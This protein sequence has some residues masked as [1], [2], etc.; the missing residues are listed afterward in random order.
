MRVRTQVALV[1]TIMLF[2]LVIMASCSK[3]IRCGEG[4]VL[5]DGVCVVVVASAKPEQAQVVLSPPVPVMEPPRLQEP[6]VNPPP[7]AS[8]SQIREFPQNVIE[9]TKNWA[10]GSSGNQFRKTDLRTSKPRIVLAGNGEWWAVCDVWVPSRQD[11]DGATV[12]LRKADSGMWVVIEAGP[13][14]LFEDVPG[15]PQD[16]IQKLQQ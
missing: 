7:P 4:T 5:K 15:I 16:V 11:V 13:E 10:I 12:V 1:S 8:K 2:M 3:E 14:V 9:A 6:S